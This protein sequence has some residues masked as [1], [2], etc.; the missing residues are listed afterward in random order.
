[1]IVTFSHRVD[2]SGQC[3]PAA[4]IPL[5]T[6]AHATS[7]IAYLLLD[8]A[9]SLWRLAGYRPGVR[10]VNLGPVDYETF[11]TDG[12]R[13]TARCDIGR[14]RGNQSIWLGRWHGWR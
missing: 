9:I 12:P 4:W 8:G 2:F 11:A 6:N 13:G 14:Q 5:V 10:R 3:D 1:M 7:G